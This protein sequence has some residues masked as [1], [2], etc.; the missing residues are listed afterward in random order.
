MSLETRRIEAY[1][2]VFHFNLLVAAV[3]FFMLPQDTL[4]QP[5]TNDSNILVPPAPAF[6]DQELRALPSDS[7]ITNGGNVFNQRFS[8][9]R[10]I[11][12]SNV[13]DLRANWRVH[14]E[15]SGLE[16][17]YSGEAQP[18]VYQGVIYIATGADDVFA[19]SVA[20]G[21]ILWR[22]SANLDPEI[23]A[24]C[25]GWISRGVA[26]GN[27]RIYLGR[28]DGKLVALDQETGKEIWS[29]Q[30]ERWQDGYTITSAPL[31]FNNMVVTGFAGAE[32]AIRGRVKA[33]DADDGSLIWTFYTI[34]EPGQPGSETWAQDNDLWKHGGASV[35]QTP[36][37]DPELGLLYF[38]TGNPGP[39]FNGA[40]RLGDNLYS[41]SIMAV[42]ARTG[43][44]RWHFQQVHHDIWDYDSTN[45]VILFDVTINGK[46]RK[47]VAEATKT[48]S[49]YILHPQNLRPHQGTV[50]PVLAIQNPCRRL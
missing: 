47:A 21:R 4:A 41:D 18:I 17:K 15:G 9:L 16:A 27:G 1:S 13:N 23:T 2:Y 28:L 40:K 36:A 7:W 24:L 29:V 50:D 39:D 19:I 12:K 35:W 43:E 31:Y 34:P 26:L 33:F 11:N 45:P 6:T 22:Y 8:P 3:C 5:V 25:C 32:Y 44:Y 48:R 42:D 14:L 37:V 49:V 30:A 20:D 10:Q 46:L 38:S